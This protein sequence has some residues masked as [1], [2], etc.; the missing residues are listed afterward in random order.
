MRRWNLQ[1]ERKRPERL[2]RLLN[3]P[4]PASA[5][6]LISA[7]D[8]A[9]NAQHTR[10]YISAAIP[11]ISEGDADATRDGPPDMQHCDQAKEQ[12]GGD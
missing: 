12:A 8:T 10:W 11:S 6:E 5:Q 1:K 7:S 4:N 9:G 2:V 3:H